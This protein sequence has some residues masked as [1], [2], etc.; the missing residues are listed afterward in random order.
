MFLLLYECDPLLF[1]C[2]HE[3]F[4]EVSDVHVEMSHHLDFVESNQEFRRFE[5]IGNLELFFYWLDDELLLEPLL[6]L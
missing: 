5:V 6:E 1:L 4:H 3:V 2:G